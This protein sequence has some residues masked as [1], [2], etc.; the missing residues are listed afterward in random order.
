MIKLW[1]F[2]VLL[3]S[4]AAAQNSG[5]VTISNSTSAVVVVTHKQSVEPLSDSE[6]QRLADARAKVDAAQKELERVEN[7]VRYTHGY[8]LARNGWCDIE[9]TL[10]TFWGDFALIE[11]NPLA[12][13]RVMW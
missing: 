2:I 6:K 5:T 9:E 12:G 11:V 7:D 8:R 13:C 10:V 3:S 1:M 4:L